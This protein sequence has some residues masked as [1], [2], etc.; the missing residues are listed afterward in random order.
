MTRRRWIALVTGALLCV[1]A[2]VLLVFVRPWQQPA[3]AGPLAVLKL[4]DAD[5]SSIES[6]VVSQDVATVSG[7]LI[8]EARD[9]FTSEGQPLLPADSELEIDTSTARG[10]QASAAKGDATVTGPQAGSYVL[11]LDYGAGHWL[12]SSAVARS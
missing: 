8:P 7:V 3:A 11:Q 6:A 2:A 4:D 1:I 12:L 5:V 9:S 10:V